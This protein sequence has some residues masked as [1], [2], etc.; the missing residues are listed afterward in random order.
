MNA[1]LKTAPKFFQRPSAQNCLSDEA[2]KKTICVPEP[3]WLAD[4][5]ERWRKKDLG[6]R[7]PIDLRD[8]YRLRKNVDPTTTNVDPTRIYYGEWMT[9][10]TLRLTH[11]RINE[12]MVDHMILNVPDEILEH[13][14]DPRIIL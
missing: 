7:T 1:T 8:L 5:E 10:L 14:A 3:E 12:E 9:S 6:I 2:L 11:Y 4:V 13:M